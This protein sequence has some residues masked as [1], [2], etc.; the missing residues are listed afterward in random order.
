VLTQQVENSRNSV[1]SLVAPDSVL[2]EREQLPEPIRR[3][4]ALRVEEG[5]QVVDNWPALDCEVVDHPSFLD[6]HFYNLPS[7]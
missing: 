5:A 4:V 7:N 1:S 6:S 3:I 2:E